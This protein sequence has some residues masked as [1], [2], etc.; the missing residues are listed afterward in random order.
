MLI[1]PHRIPTMKLHSKLVWCFGHFPILS[2]SFF[3]IPHAILKTGSVFVFSEKREE[4]SYCAAIQKG[5]SPSLNQHPPQ[6]QDPP[7]HSQL[8]MKNPTFCNAV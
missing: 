4:R 2:G 8:N 6:E 3:P 7:L 5:R 1:Q